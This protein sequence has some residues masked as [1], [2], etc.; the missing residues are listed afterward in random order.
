MARLSGIAPHLAI[1]RRVQ[2]L[3]NPWAELLRAFLSRRESHVHNTRV[4][5]QGRPRWFN[6]HK[7]AIDISPNP[8]DLSQGW[9]GTV[10]V[11]EDLTELQT[12][13]AELAHS[14][15]LASIGRLA[16]GVAHE[17][18]NPVTG[19]A[20]IAQ[21][22]R[23]EDD[24]EIIEESSDD[25]LQQTQRISAIVQSLVTFSHSGTIDGQRFSHF[26]LYD[27]V[28]DAQR[29]VTLSHTAKQIEHINACDDTLLIEGDK[30]QLLQVFVNLLNNASDA[31]NPGNRIR[32]SNRIEGE[33]VDI[34]VSDQGAGI[35]E[36][37]QERVFEP[38]FTTK[39][40]GKGTGLGL[41]LVYNIIRDH[42][43]SISIDSQ[44][45]QGTCVN[46][47]LPLRQSAAG[48]QPD[49]GGAI[50]S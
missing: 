13:E 12:L 10:I 5:I 9:G 20:C 18:G 43:G 29:L 44:P 25:I 50:A 23:Y 27:C 35:P 11:V 1:G 16:A 42:G 24:P 8:H 30:Q 19:I 3:P 38:F 7:S 49:A 4:L 41:S 47:R 31:S 39:D 21:N 37:F 34:M 17:I 15:R 46:L 22:L 6:L 28:A 36:A 40:P 45:N 26:R 14:E 33:I 32:I 48:S 2:E